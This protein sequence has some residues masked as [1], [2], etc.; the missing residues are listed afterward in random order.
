MKVDQILLA[1][2][3]FL[4]PT[5]LDFITE[6]AMKMEKT[7]SPATT[8]QMGR[9]GTRDTARRRASVLTE[10]GA[11]EVG[12]FFRAR[13]EQALPSVLQDLQLPVRRAS[14]ISVQITST[15]DRGFYKPHVDNSPQDSNRRV[16][17]FVYFCHRYPVSFQGG[18][19]RVFSTRSH[20]ELTNPGVQVHAISPEQ[21]RIVFFMSD[22]VHEI[23][24]VVCSSNRLADTRL[25]V[26]GWIY[27]D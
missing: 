24:P 14:R 20:A 6:Y 27:F 12:K 21:N 7:F 2:D 1:F 13:I 16:L 25:T 15:G 11:G 8:V 22:F 23:C 5:E 19:L 9:P 17:S 26:N 10:V 4:M 18:E 3:Q